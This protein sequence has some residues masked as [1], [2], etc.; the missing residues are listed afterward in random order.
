MDVEPASSPA[1]KGRPARKHSGRIVIRS[2]RAVPP[3]PV[4]QHVD[5]EQAV[6][7]DLPAATPVLLDEVGI[8]R[9]YLGREIDAILLGEK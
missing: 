8:L 9:A 1:S 3:P 2:E 4:R 5:G 7:S 6:V